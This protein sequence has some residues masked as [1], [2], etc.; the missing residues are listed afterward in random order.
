MAY[1]LISEFEKEPAWEA[2]H[3]E[4]E[5]V[6]GGIELFP[7][8]DHGP[9]LG[10]AIPRKAAK[11]AAHELEAVLAV[12]TR[13]EGVTTD[14]YSGKQVDAVEYEEIRRRLMI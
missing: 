10:I 11:D 13:F 6:R 1:C 7:M 12:V 2:L 5:R 9:A 8:N 3:N 4:L 14:L